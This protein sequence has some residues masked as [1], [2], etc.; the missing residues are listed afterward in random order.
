[1]SR[2]TTGKPFGNDVLVNILPV[3]AI[4]AAG[5]TPVLPLGRGGIQQPRIPSEGSGNR[6]AVVESNAQG[7]LRERYADD[8]FVSR[9]HQYRLQYSQPRTADTTYPR[10]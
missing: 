2:R 3:N 6:A 7:I 8:S 9:Q 1:G 5:D 4:T 10:A